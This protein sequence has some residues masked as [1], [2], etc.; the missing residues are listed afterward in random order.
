MRVKRVNRE[1]EK[2]EDELAWI[3]DEDVRN[4]Q[5]PELDCHIE[6]PEAY[7]LSPP[8]LR[9]ASSLSRDAMGREGVWKQ[10]CIL[11]RR[12][13]NSKFYSSAAC[14]CCVNPSC[15]WSPAR[16]LSDLVEYFVFLKDCADFVKLAPDFAE[17]RISHLPNEIVEDNILPLLKE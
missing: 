16:K 5:V 2:R 10:I 4:L 6:I 7:P 12:E 3:F 11:A 9:K 8:K 14:P 1:I 15:S 13:T 17:C